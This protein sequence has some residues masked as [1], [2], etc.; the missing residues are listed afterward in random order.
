[1]KKVLIVIDMQN[2]FVCGTLANPQAQSI[3]DGIVKRIDEF[4]GDVI[5]T[6]DTHREDYLTTTEGKH[7]PV[8]HCVKGTNGWEIVPAIAQALQRRN[9]VILDKPTFGYLNWGILQNYDEAEMVGTCT[10]ICVVSNA[11]IIKATHPDLPLSVRAS[12]CAGT[13]PQNHDSALAVMACCQ[14]KIV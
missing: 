12:L 1:M 13:T 7:L 5:A 6:R 8:T 9:A 3:V 4:D 10:D 11:L 14:V 2:D